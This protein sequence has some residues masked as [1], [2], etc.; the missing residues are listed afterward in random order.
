VEVLKRLFDAV[1]R[2]RGELWRD[3]LIHHH[4]NAQEHFSLRMSQFLVG[5]GIPTMDHP[6]CSPNLAPADFSLF[7]KL[8]S[9]LKGKRFLNAEDNIYSVKKILTD[10]PVQDF[11]NCFEQWPKRYEHCK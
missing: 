10:I 5:K 6:P 7:P 4:Y 9:V 3:S 11:K 8:K 2:K 1:R